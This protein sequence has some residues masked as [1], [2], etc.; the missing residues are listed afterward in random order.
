M[1]SDND[2]QKDEL[3]PSETIGELGAALALMEKQL[4]AIGERLVHV[5]G[6]LDN[7][8]LPMEEQ[9]CA[10]SKDLAQ[11]KEQS[12][13]MTRDLA[14][15]KEA[16]EDTE[17]GLRALRRD[18]RRSDTLALAQSVSRSGV[19]VRPELPPRIATGR[20]FVENEWRWASRYDR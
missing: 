3:R 6:I 8:L 11:V 17:K 15:V 9:L 4:R 18:E 1:T 5:N 10:I 12:Y 20:G 16:G 13:A 7:K 14:Q 2:M 19:D